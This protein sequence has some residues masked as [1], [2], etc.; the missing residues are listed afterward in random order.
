MLTIPV[1]PT[2]CWE[3]DTQ[4]LVALV[5]EPCES[6][7]PLQLICL[8]FKR[9]AQQAVANA[10]PRSPGL[11]ALLDVST[12]HGE[13]ND[14][15]Q[16]L[17]ALIDLMRGNFLA[18]DAWVGYIDVIR[19]I[20][21]YASRWHHSPK[22]DGVRFCFTSKQSKLM[23]NVTKEATSENVENTDSPETHQNPLYKS[24]L[25]FMVAVCCCRH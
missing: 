23:E 5:T 6:K 13:G 8:A 24:Y 17:A 1:G 7:V 25:D 10:P 19:T 15:T 18:Q 9:L 11:R 22:L 21:C 4:D 3:Q 20:L 12:E 16:D 14:Y 2:H